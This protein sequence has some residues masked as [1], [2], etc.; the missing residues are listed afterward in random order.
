MIL[1]NP[2]IVST[3]EVQIFLSFELFA[4]FP[5]SFRSPLHIFLTTIE[6]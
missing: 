6:Q 4:L 3:S 2:W 1:L 5:I